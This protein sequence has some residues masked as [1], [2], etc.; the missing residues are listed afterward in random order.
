MISPEES[1]RL[2][3]QLAELERWCRSMRE[4]LGQA[5]AEAEVPTNIDD[6]VPTLKR[7]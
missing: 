7:P 4:D 3:A 2:R 6:R 5:V 1:S